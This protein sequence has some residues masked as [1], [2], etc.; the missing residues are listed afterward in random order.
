MRTRGRT[1]FSKPRRQERGREGF[2]LIELLV[3]L[4][5]I[6]ILIAILLPSLSGARNRSRIT[7]CQS[8]L[9]ELAGA[10]LRYIGQQDDRFPVNADCTNGNCVY[11]NGHQYFG[12]NGRLPNPNGNQWIRYLNREL[13]LE[14]QEQTSDNARLAECPSD[15]GA[16]GQTGL[17]D[18]LFDALGTS[19]PLNPILCQG[20]YSD[21][22]YRG[23]DLNLSQ[24]IQPS[25]K[26]LVADHVA[27]G[28]TYDGF[29][30]G[31]R[32]G[33]HDR[34]RPAAVVGFIDGHADYVV[35][36]CG[37]REWQWY[38]EASGAG[39]IRDLPRKVHWEVLEGC[40]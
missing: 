1:N 15:D 18:R 7:K 6:S 26:V 35:G 30:T 21:W 17:T 9:R 2:T 28:L 24:I 8:N 40:E 10:T 25:Q 29:W 16:P 22:K 19:Y 34:I 27:F 12:W 20:R 38:G 32:P 14:L 13:G 23:T 39:F 11:W 3:V 31:I 4:A 36:R 33:W 5:I 37:L